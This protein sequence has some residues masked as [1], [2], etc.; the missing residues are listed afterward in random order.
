MLAFRLATG[1]AEGFMQLYT[2]VV[3]MQTVPED[4]A[5]TFVGM[6]EGMR[7]LGVVIGPLYGGPLYTAGGWYLPYLILG[8]VMIPLGFSVSVVGGWQPPRMT[9]QKTSME[10]RRDLSIS[11]IIALMYTTM[12]STLR[13]LRNPLPAMQHAKR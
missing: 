4:Q 9:M 13:A 8:V 10:K 1:L 11:P 3:V 6:M 2:M 5:P 7:T 12:M